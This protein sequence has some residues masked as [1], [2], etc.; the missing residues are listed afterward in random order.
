MIH[1]TD[2]GPAEELVD[3]VAAQD[4]ERVE[5]LFAPNVRFRAL[6]PNGLREDATAADA[7]AR[8]RGWFGDCDPLELLDSEVQQVADRV[9]VRYRF[10]A[11]E[12]GNWHLVEQQAYLT[13]E[14]GRISD[15][16]ILC[17]GFRVVD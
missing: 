14:D 5:T 17:S 16:T 2:R 12:E 1:T 10:H 7:A 11:R 15:I 4:F 6:I 9:H 3:A 13:V 8:M